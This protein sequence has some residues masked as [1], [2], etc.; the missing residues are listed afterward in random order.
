VMMSS[1]QPIASEGEE[2]ATVAETAAKPASPFT[3]EERSDGW[4]DLRTT[5]S[6]AKKERQGAWDQ[7]NEMYISKGAEAA[8][9]GGRWAK[10]LAEELVDSK[11]IESVQPSVE[12]LREIVP[13]SKPK[14]A[15]QQQKKVERSSFELPKVTLPTVPLDKALTQRAAKAKAAKEA[16]L[17]KQKEEEEKKKAAAKA[18]SNSQLLVAA[19]TIVFLGGSTAGVSALLISQAAPELFQSLFQPILDALN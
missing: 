6:K 5:I 9:K 4:D 11:V 2:S 19:L 16:Q 15:G 8:K 13:A 17:Q 14:E 1:E 18:A 7:L 10:V 3:L 12:K